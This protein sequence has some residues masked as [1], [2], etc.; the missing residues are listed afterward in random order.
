[1]STNNKEE[2]GNTVGPVCDFLLS[3]LPDSIFLT[4]PDDM[5]GE[6]A[7]LV[8]RQ[9]IIDEIA[10]DRVWLVSQLRHYPANERAAA[11][12]PFEIDGTVKIPG[13]VDLRPTVRSARLFR[14]NFDETEFSLQLRVAHDFIAER[15]ATSCD[16]LNHRLH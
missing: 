9:K 16:H 12:M 14:P 4:A 2:F 13:A 15:S 3:W 11:G 10:D 7:V 1:M 6:N 5:N 8:A